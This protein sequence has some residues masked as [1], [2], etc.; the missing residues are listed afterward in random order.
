MSTL[1]FVQSSPDSLEIV[2]TSGVPDKITLAEGVLD[3][4]VTP[5]GFV[6]V[7][8]REITVYGVS[9]GSVKSGSV[10]PFTEEMARIET[11]CESG[12]VLLRLLGSR[13]QALIL[14]QTARTIG[15]AVVP[16]HSILSLG[17]G[18]LTVVDG[19]SIQL[20][21]ERT[22]RP[23]PN[24]LLKHSVAVRLAHP[25]VVDGEPRLAWLD[26]NRDLFVAPLAALSDSARITGGVLDFCW[27]PG[28]P[29]LAFITQSGEISV[30]V[31]PGAFIAPELIEKSI[32]RV[33][34][35]T[36]QGPTHQLN[37]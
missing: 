2:R 34:V 29:L 18:A 4:A 37:V 28:T 32:T 21:D 3:A 22:G 27:I 10:A 7:A 36:Q 33:A 13:T 24:G 19:K 6:V 31:S 35:L 26:A 30:V 25:A 20:M 12:R 14:D 1:S 15:R 16:N 8:P 5:T 9:S 11:R 17:A 23:L